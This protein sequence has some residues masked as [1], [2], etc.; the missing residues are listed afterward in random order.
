M[1]ISPKMFNDRRRAS[2]F[3]ESGRNFKVWGRDKR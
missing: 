1:F 3:D 2:F